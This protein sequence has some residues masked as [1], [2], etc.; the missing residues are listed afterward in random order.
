MHRIKVLF[1]AAN[2]VDTAPLHLDEEIRE[3]TRK[4]RAS[5]NRDSLD[6]VS[7]FAVRADDLLQALNEHRPT[8]VHFS[9][10]GNKQGEIVLLDKGG[11]AKPVSQRAVK[12]LFT[13]LKD[14]VRVVVLNACYSESQSQAI[15]AVIDSAIG[16]TTSISDP[17]AII[18]AA[19]FYGA[20]G[21]GRSVREAFD[22]GRVALLL[23]GIPEEDIPQLITRSGVDP[24]DIVLIESIQNPPTLGAPAPDVLRS[25]VDELIAILDIRAARLVRTISRY[26]DNSQIQEYL[27][28]FG[29]LHQ[30]HIEALKRGQLLHAH[31]ILIQI[32]ELSYKL[33][34]DEFWR[35]QTAKR[36]TAIHYA[37]LDFLERGV[38]SRGYLTGSLRGNS[39]ELSGRLLALLSKPSEQ[40]ALALYKFISQSSVLQTEAH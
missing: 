26:A 2:P 14:N 8:I 36:P 20:L 21:A 24:S 10:H 4:I 6:L 5:D 28:E 37:P 32:H 35:N 9:G 23:E 13:A 3:I 17:A 25:R 1:L 39:P 30:Q 19:S 11:T 16:M 38:V 29:S 34:T 7:V 31:E 15:T 12:E 22:Q 18:F 27:D 40:D 33:E